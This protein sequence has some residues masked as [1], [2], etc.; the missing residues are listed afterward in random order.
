MAG[1][2]KIIKTGMSGSS[3]GH[4]LFKNNTF[5]P[6]FNVAPDDQEKLYQWTKEICDYRLHYHF[7]RRV[8]NKEKQ[9]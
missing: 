1:A 3:K 7:E 4:I 9:G 8:N 5:Y 6:S 2:L